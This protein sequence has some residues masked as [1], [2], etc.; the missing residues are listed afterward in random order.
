[1]NLRTLL[2]VA[3]LLFFGCPKR[4]ETDKPKEGP[5]RPFRLLAETAQRET[6]QLSEK[7]DD[8]EIDTREYDRTPGVVAKGETPLIKL[9]GARARLFGDEAMSKGWEVDNLIL[10]E[11]LN[12]SGQV[13]NRA[14]IGFAPEGVIQG[15]E[16]ID[17][18]GKMGFAFEP[19]EIDLTSKLPENEPFKI[20]ATA[21]DYS[22]VGRVSDVF[23][24]LDYGGRGSSE[25]D[26]LRAE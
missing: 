2:P 16:R 9:E 6:T 1:M 24:V 26:D 11:V 7:R 17:N 3:A 21:L 13:I 15:K 10:I 25:G 19:G 4:V 12:A 14:A 23:V 5:P 20:R 8:I 18:I 22:G